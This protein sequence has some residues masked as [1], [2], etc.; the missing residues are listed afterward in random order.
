MP[1]FA[2][3]SQYTPQE[4]ALWEA[5]KEHEGEEFVTVKGLRYTYTITGNELFVDRRGKSIT[6]ATVNLAYQK[7]RELEG[8]VSGP[9]LLGV[10]GASYLYPI[11]LRLGVITE[12]ETGQEK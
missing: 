11:F 9:K 2:D 7:V 8:K 1:N 4:L 3:T 6:R 12:A 5:L 10:F